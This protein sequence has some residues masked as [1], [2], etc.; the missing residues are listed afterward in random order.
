MSDACTIYSTTVD[1]NKVREIIEAISSRP[2]KII[3]DAGKWLEIEVNGKSK[4][5]FSTMERIPGGFDEFSKLVLGTYSFFQHTKP[6]SIGNKD[7]TLAAI[8]KCQFAIGVV[9]N[10]AFD[11]DEQ[12]FDIIFAIAKVLNGLIF[13]GSGMIDE[14]GL[15]VLDGDG[16][17]D[18]V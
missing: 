1:Y 18:L 16:N 7:R 15:L 4:I 14:N 2:I 3:G 5:T 10:P 8:S 6:I 17:S 9:A 13:N 12:H 11:E